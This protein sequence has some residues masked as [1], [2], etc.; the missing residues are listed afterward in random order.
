MLGLRKLIQGLFGKQGA[1]AVKKSTPFILDVFFNKKRKKTKFAV[2][3]T[4]RTD[5]RINVRLN[6]R[7][8]DR[9][10]PIFSCWP[11]NPDCFRLFNP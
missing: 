6:G 9:L 11:H 10:V 5:G 3:G 1:L 7:A 8:S 2:F 4:A